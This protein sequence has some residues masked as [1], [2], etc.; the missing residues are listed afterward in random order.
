MPAAHNTY[1][2]NSDIPMDGVYSYITNS[3]AVPDNNFKMTIKIEKPI[4][5]KLI[6][7]GLGIYTKMN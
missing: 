1:I 6:E 3:Y 4:S 5:P 7:S 2:D